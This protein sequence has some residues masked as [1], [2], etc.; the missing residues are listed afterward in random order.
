V[1]LIFVLNNRF[2]VYMQKEI[3]GDESKG[4]VIDICSVYRRKTSNLRMVAMK[5]A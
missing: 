5:V 4:F 2:S 1:L 3:M